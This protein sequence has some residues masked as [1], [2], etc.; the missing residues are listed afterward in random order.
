MRLWRRSRPRSG[1]VP[2]SAVHDDL[3]APVDYDP[4]DDVAARGRYQDKLQPFL[5]NRLAVID[6]GVPADARSLLDVGCNLGDI[7]AHYA[8]RGVWSVGA[9]AN[10]D[11][12]QEAVERQ[13]GIESC[14]FMVSMLDPENVKRL[15]EFDTILLLSVH[16]HWLGEWGPDVAGRMLRDVV[17]RATRSVVFESTSRNGRFGKYPPG[18]VDNDEASVTAYHEA[19]LR[20]HVGDIA[21]IERLG[22]TPCVGEREP[23]RWVW[24]LRRS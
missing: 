3:P 10:R 9:D 19:Y 1:W 5:G 12:V 21:T 6:R 18:F 20:E 16:H 11:L 22:K 4:G 7:T 13:R 14:A 15:P 24:A 23:Y 8:R 17:A 2:A